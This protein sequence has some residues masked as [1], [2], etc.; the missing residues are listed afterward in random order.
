MA[1]SEMKQVTEIKCRI[2][3]GKWG[4]SHAQMINMSNRAESEKRSVKEK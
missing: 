4:N 2:G 3:K 1:G